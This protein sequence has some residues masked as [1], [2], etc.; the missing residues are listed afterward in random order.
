[1]TDSQVIVN[2][3]LEASANPDDP[4]PAYLE[5]VQPAVNKYLQNNDFY[6][7]KGS[8]FKTVGTYTVRVNLHPK[9]VVISFWH[10]TFGS[11]ANRSLPLDSAL[12]T[13]SKLLAVLQAN[14]NSLL[15][16]DDLI[17]RLTESISEATDPDNPNHYID[18]LGQK[19]ETG[20]L[21]KIRF[22]AHIHLS[23]E[24]MIRENAHESGIDVD[25]QAF[26][27][28][29][30]RCEAIIESNCLQLLREAGLHVSDEGMTI[31]T[32]GNDS[33]RV[34]SVWIT[35]E[36]EDRKMALLKAVINWADGNWPSTASG[37]MDYAFGADTTQRIYAMT[38][39]AARFIDVTIEFTGT[40]ALVEWSRLN[41]NEAAIDD[42]DQYLK[43]NVYT[44]NELREKIQEYGFGIHNNGISPWGRWAVING[45]TYWAV[46]SED[47]D[48]YLPQSFFREHL[49]KFC[50]EMGFT[51]YHIQLLGEYPAG[52]TFKLAVPKMQVEPEAYGPSAWQRDWLPEDAPDDPD[53]DDPAVNI[54][55]H[56][57]DLD[58]STIMARLGFKDRRDK[59]KIMAHDT[60]WPYWTKR[61]GN[62]EWRV[63]EMSGI[64]R[65]GVTRMERPAK[66]VRTG[67]GGFMVKP[68]YGRWRDMGH[69]T[70]HVSDLENLLRGEG[71]LDPPPVEEALDPDD[72]AINVKRHM[73]AMDAA[74]ILEPL[75]F[76][77]QY[78]MWDCADKDYKW[79]TLFNRGLKWTVIR[80]SDD[81]PQMMDVSIYRMRKA[82]TVYGPLVDWQEIGGFHTHIGDLKKKMEK[83][84]TLPW[85][86]RDVDWGQNVTTLNALGENLD[87][88]LPPE[89]ANPKIYLNRLADANLT[90]LYREHGLDSNEQGDFGHGF[91]D[92]GKPAAISWHGK[93]R[94]IDRIKL[95][96]HT[97][98]FQEVSSVSVYILALEALHGTSLKRLKFRYWSVPLTKLREVVHKIIYEIEGICLVNPATWPEMVVQFKAAMKQFRAYKPLIVKKKKV[99]EDT[100]DL[101]V[102]DPTPEFMQATFDVP[103]ILKRLGY[104]RSGTAEWTKIFPRMPTDQDLMVEVKRVGHGGEENEAD[105]VYDTT[106]YRYPV[107]DNPNR[108]WVPLAYRYQRNNKQLERVLHKI[109]DRIRRNNLRGIC[110]DV[111]DPPVRVEEASKETVDYPAI[112]ADGRIF[113]G[114]SH[115]HIIT[116]LEDAKIPLN[117][118]VLHGWWTSRNRFLATDI[119]VN[120][121]IRLDPRFN[122]RTGEDPGVRGEEL[123][124]AKKLTGVREV[125]ESLDDPESFVRNFV[126]KDLGVTF[127]IHKSGD[128]SVYA[129]PPFRDDWIIYSDDKEMPDDYNQDDPEWERG[130]RTFE[131]Y[132]RQRNDQWIAYSKKTPAKPL[133]A[134]PTTG[135][136]A[137]AV[138]KF[139]RKQK[140]S[141]DVPP[142]PPEPD[143]D[144]P[145]DVIKSHEK[146]LLPAELKRLNFSP[147]PEQGKGWLYGVE[148]P[149]YWWNRYPATDGKIH[150]LYVY[151]IDGQTPEVR[152]NN[153]N[154]NAK[155]WFQRGNEAPTDCPAK[156]EAHFCAIIRDLDEAVKRCAADSLSPEREHEALENVLNHHRKW[157]DDTL[158]Y[159]AK[160]GL[161]GRIGPGQPA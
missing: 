68:R 88:P 79:W 63:W 2:K 149:R 9:Y 110:A 15:S 94:L 37:T 138:Y 78:P 58:I 42:P 133:G 21:D 64:N 30:E 10:H 66:I 67:R 56:T 130:T 116:H 160:S 154:F 26:W 100:D 109:E 41:L 102:D 159:V 18:W 77:V 25:S 96:I 147:R 101:N 4:V 27:D 117:G 95:A 123:P 84:L 98:T 107:H 124:K 85:G 146:S 87:V 161:P 157:F 156:S 136:A 8:Y 158:D 150:G 86:G 11:T 80:K 144:D 106:V 128:D 7:V 22:G 16:A 50:K 53:P 38:E 47:P 51:I 70:C 40:E 143:P 13:I 127:L 49:E 59:T 36:E 118:T 126:D 142:P 72:P 81:E 152:A 73:D 113:T 92:I 12:E 55:R 91:V 32:P 125:H 43:G 71:V 120:E 74:T 48:K 17:N 108:S 121:L 111:D 57:D 137:Y 14:K 104:E 139:N 76:R 34:A 54:E 114:P 61:V 5:K 6:I 39:E 153:W 148:M 1:M 103:T 141:L 82:G 75:G 52:I 19:V 93:A 69:F 20:P 29:V 60:G 28:E 90:D 24:D 129:Q 23:S 65:Y 122:Q 99:V 140:E 3:L 35:T 44:F 151:F 112:Y 89:D 145:N 119:D 97:H 155:A 46:Y 131:G 45:F 135:E 132:L 33:T 83:A 134:F 115:Y 31:G 105:V 62:K